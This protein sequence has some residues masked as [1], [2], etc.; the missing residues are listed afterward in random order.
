MLWFSQLEGRVVKVEGVVLSKKTL[1]SKN[2]LVW[3]NTMLNYKQ[4]QCHN[5]HYYANN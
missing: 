2:T 4:C 5:V 3:T 1:Q